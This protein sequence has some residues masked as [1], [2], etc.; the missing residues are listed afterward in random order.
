V[1]G[2]ANVVLDVNLHASIGYDAGL[3]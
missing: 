3:F 2:A 1:D